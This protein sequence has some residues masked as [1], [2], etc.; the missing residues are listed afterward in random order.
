MPQAEALAVLFFLITTL[1]LLRLGDALLLLFGLLVLMADAAL[2]AAFGG[3]PLGFLALALLGIGALLT[4]S[5]Q[6]R[7]RWGRRPRRLLPPSEREP[8]EERYQI[9]GKIGSGGMAAVY[10]ARRKADGL[11][12][13]LKVP[14]ERFAH[15]PRFLK[16]LHRE[17]EV[18]RRLNHPNIVKVYE[19]GQAGKTHFI[20]MELIE[21]P[22]L[23]ELIAERQLNPELAVKILKPVAEALNYLHRQGFLHRDLKPGNIMIYKSAL[24]DGDVDPK[25][26]RLMDFGI[27]A[28]KEFARLTT[29]GARIGTPT[30]M[31]PEQAKGEALNEK[32]DVYSFGVVLY[33]ALV[34]EPPFTGNFEQV[35]QRQIQ[36]KPIP[37]IQKNPEIP[38]TLNDLILRMLAKRQEDRPDLAE[39]IEILA[40]PE[41]WEMGRASSYALVAAL[42]HHGRA[43]RLMD[44]EGFPIRAFSKHKFTDLD[45]DPEGNIW[46][47]AF[48]LS[49]AQG[50]IHRYSPE[51]EELLSFGPYGMKLGEFLNPTAIAVNADRQVFVLDSETQAITRFNFTGFPETRFAGRGP[52]RGTFEDAKALV[53]AGDLFVL[54]VGRRR[55]ERL[56][57]DG[58]YKD[59]I[60]FAKSVDDPTPRALLGLG[61]D[62]D[63]RLLIFDAL[64]QKIRRVT[65]DGRLIDSLAVPLKE[66]DDP[67]ALIDVFEAPDG[68][69]Y[70]ARRGNKRIWK[71]RGNE[72]QEIWVGLP[73][74]AL[75]LWQ[76]GRYRP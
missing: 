74:R 34:G 33:E 36:E 27:A 75:A 2:L 41:R 50:M 12:A 21:G 51:G 59:R 18:L 64:A 60:V 71:L 1:L 15:E 14:Q 7:I 30:Y 22:G 6:A 73:V 11:V 38:K 67:L 25:G 46:A 23:D 29:V 47:V 5:E 63:D 52:G 16:R 43:L 42:D 40:H 58:R 4:P 54:D 53:W 48:E 55:V 8:L 56:D 32:S 72:V 61:L 10:R 66:D 57:A 69:I 28:G 37:P 9:L 31:S 65:P 20:A 17:A 44:P 76:K 45:V 13:A 35:V 49:G 3:R 24:K 26:V 70:A 39:V 68:W 62:Q 19:H